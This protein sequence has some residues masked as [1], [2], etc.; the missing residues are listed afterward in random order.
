[1][2]KHILVPLDGSK[3]AESALPAAASLASKTKAAVTLFHVVEQKAPAEIHHER[4]LTKADE[5]N[6]YLETVAQKYFAKDANVDHHVHTAEVKDVAASIVEH[7]QELKSDLIV[8]CAHGRSGVRDVLFGS[9]A[10]QVIARGGTPVL[11]LRASSM[12]APEAFDIKRIMLP[13]DSESEHDESFPYAVELAQTYDAAILMVTVIPTYGTLTGEEAATSSLLPGT[14]AA[15]LDIKEQTAR[16]HLKSHEDEL[17]KSGL[18]IFT[19]TARGDPASIIVSEAE[20]LGADLMLLA[21][22]RKAGVDAFWARSVAPEV[23]RRTKLPLLLLPL[24]E[25]TISKG[26]R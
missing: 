7:A 1:M 25:K 5:A 14:T 8:M 9:I 12:S 15:L 3:L 23:A 26:P 10:L 20:R 18:E 16:D 24:K 21:T 4:H 2:F 13:L 22:H 17:K 6:T 11:L 19:E